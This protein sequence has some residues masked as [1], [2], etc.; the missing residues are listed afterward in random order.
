MGRNKLLNDEIRKEAEKYLRDTENM[1]A[2]TLLPTIDGLA[3]YIKIHR[4]T[5]YQW[6][7]EDPDWADF[8]DELRATQAEKLIQNGLMGRYN[9]PMSKMLLSKH[10]YVEQSSVDHTTKGKQLP[11]PILGGMSV[12]PTD[13]GDEEASEA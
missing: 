9:A 6:E 5:V 7:K 2:N 4:D 10:G 3:L 11:T 13:N 1:S 12:L 8:L